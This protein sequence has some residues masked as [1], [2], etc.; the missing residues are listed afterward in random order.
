MMAR[1]L[2]AAFLLFMLALT[3]LA[4]ACAPISTAGG[5]RGPRAS[6]AT[7]GEA[8][9]R[10]SGVRQGDGDIVR[11]PRGSDA[12]RVDALSRTILDQ[13]NQARRRAGRQVLLPD[14]RLDRA[15]QSCSRRASLTPA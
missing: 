6:A 14:E 8:G 12:A 5:D 10:G 3:A 2:P 15:A 13:A 4:T 11:A 9:G 1:R 7:V